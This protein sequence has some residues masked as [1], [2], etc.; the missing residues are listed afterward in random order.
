MELSLDLNIYEL[1]LL[2]LCFV[3]I[4]E[5]V[6]YTLFPNFMKKVSIYILNSKEDKIRLLGLIFC[7]LGLIILYFLQ[8]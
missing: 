2:S 7:V 1:L 6:L 3:F 4:L 8:L 5:G